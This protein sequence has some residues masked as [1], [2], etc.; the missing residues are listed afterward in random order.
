MRDK[1][2]TL[3]DDFI[4]GYMSSKSDF[5]HKVFGRELLDKIYNIVKYLFLWLA[6][7]NKTHNAIGN[8][9]LH[10]ELWNEKKLPTL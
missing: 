6:L 2:L 9:C 10:G 4:H 3:L 8:P 1:A 7:I 5:M